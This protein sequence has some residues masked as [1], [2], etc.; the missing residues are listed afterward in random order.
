MAT[1]F[2]NSKDTTNVPGTTLA[3]NPHSTMHINDRDAI[4]ALE[5][6][7][8]TGSTAQTASDRAFLIGTG[9]GASKWEAAPTGVGL[10]NPTLTGADMNG[11]E[12]ILDADADTSITS[13]TDDQI[14]F[15]LNG[16]D[17]FRMTAN[18][19]TALAGST[20]A[21]DTIAETTAGA[22]ITADGVLLK[23]GRIQTSGAVDNTSVIAGMP[24]QIVTALSSAANTTT[25]AIPADDS[26][27]QKTEGGEF[28]TVT[29]TPKSATN[30]LLIQVIAYGNTSGADNSIGALFQDSASD[31]IA[32]TSTRHSAGDAPG[33]LSITHEVTAGTTSPITFKF[34][35]GPQG[36]TTYTF[37]GAAATRQFSTTTKSS[38]VV[39]EYKA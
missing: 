13:D 37:N 1:N 20:V 19:L 8:G 28:M 33:I 25:A 21:T 39:T 2:P 23:D 9:S 15:K 31:A 24:V 12:L 35:A 17:D 16:A 18:T 6:K 11:T 34:R 14:D 29:I 38:M 30:K 3:S 4:I 10:T 5:N 27:P 7:L 26:P 36:A 22:G 32:A